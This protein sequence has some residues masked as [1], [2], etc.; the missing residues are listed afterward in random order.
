MKLDLI[1]NSINNNK[2][3]WRNN[4]SITYEKK[5]KTPAQIN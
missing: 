5:Q 1:T 4:K 2:L 3:L